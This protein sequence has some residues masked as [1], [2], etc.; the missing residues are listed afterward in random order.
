MGLETGLQWD[1]A[2]EA[3]FLLAS[4]FRTLPVGTTNGSGDLTISLPLS[5]LGSGVQ[6]DMFYLQP[7]FVGPGGAQQLGTPITLA[8]LDQAF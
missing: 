3:N 8:A 6:S 2:H 5:D 4:P 7:L 1:P